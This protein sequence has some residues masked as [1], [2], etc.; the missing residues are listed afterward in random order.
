[1]IDWVCPPRCALCG[2]GVPTAAS[3]ACEGC[4]RALGEAVTRREVVPS[5]LSL[6]PWEGELREAVLAMKF[7]GEVWRGRPLGRLLGLEVA[8]YEVD[9]DVIVPVPVARGRAHERGFNQA[10]R[11][12]RGVRDVL[13]AP[14]CPRALRRLDRGRQ[15]ER[16]RD[17]R[18]SASFALRAPEAVRGLA[19]LL[20]DD[21]LST[22]ATADACRAALERGGARAVSVATLCYTPTRPAEHEC[23]DP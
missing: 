21:V 4:G 18:R 15:S 17:A 5:T 2:R 10:D 1:M 9:V 11:I 12:A 8:A 3:A 13:G 6:A 22:G 16:T 19:V 7:R 23:G 14:L 20:V